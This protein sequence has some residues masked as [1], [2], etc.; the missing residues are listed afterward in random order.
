[1]L[2]FRRESGSSK[3][4]RYRGE[5]FV[6]LL[7][8]DPRGEISFHVTSPSDEPH[9]DLWRFLGQNDSDWAFASSITFSE[10]NGLAAALERLSGLLARNASLLTSPNDLLLPRLR[11]IQDEEVRKGWQ[12]EQL[13]TALQQAEKLWKAKRYGE[14]LEL[15]EPWEAMLTPSAIAKLS[16]CRRH[17]P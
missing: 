15:L 7:Y 8:I 17:L 6:L 10:M 16:Y 4:R 13:E 11:K 5:Q 12:H 9:V 14:Y 2:G 3:G 1:M